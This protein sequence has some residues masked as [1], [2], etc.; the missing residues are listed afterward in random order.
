[1]IAK[2]KKRP[3]MAASVLVLSSLKARITKRPSMAALLEKANPKS[4]NKKWAQGPFHS[5]PLYRIQTPA[6][7]ILR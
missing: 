7:R 4:T 6:T 5:P 2:I 3:S 1:M